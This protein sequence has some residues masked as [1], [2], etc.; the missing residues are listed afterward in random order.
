MSN[1]LDDELIP[2]ST[3]EPQNTTGLGGRI[4]T[5]FSNRGTLI[6]AIGA[7]IGGVALLCLFGYLIFRSDG[8]GEDLPPATPPAAGAPTPDSDTYSYQA[9]NESGTISV[10]LETPVF[11]SV[12]GDDFS[13]QAAFVPESGAWNPTVTNETTALWVYGSIINY[14]FGLDDTNQ[15]RSLLEGLSPGDEIRLTS[16]SGRESTFTVESL[17]LLSSDNEEIFSQHVPGITLVLLEE[18]L[19]EER[20]VATASFKLPDTQD[21]ALRGRV[22]E[23]GETA[24]LD[25][26]QVTVNSVSHQVDRP[27]APA[28]FSFFVIDY[29]VFNVGTVP[30]DANSL[31]MVLADD[32]GNLYALNPIA[33]QLGN[34]PFLTGSVA[35]GQSALAT[36]GYQ[37]P[38]GLSS[39]TLRW[40]VA[41][42]GTASQ[43]QV[44]IPFQSRQVADYQASIQLS[45]ATVSQDG[46]SL[47][48]TGQITNLGD[49]PLLIDVADVN[50]VSPLGTVFQMLS[51]N[52]AFPWTI[53]PGQALVYGVTFQRPLDPE[54]TFNLLNQSFQLTGL[55]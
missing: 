39:P 22:V 5:L 34:Y 14:V 17:E 28:G 6:V 18:D 26:L 12:T 31:N 47:L 11:L 21:A 41:I 44:N 1:P 29:Q 25:G 38:L 20:L 48:L 54:A 37:I 35:T 52:P 32:L 3:P 50:L 24:Q 23:I 46:G 15:N 33:S 30:F 16:R 8:D 40:Q 49:T 43:I 2:S 4:R 10:T 42:A 7:T 55:R 51:T 9:I 13:V 27:E 45:Q 36:A 19:D 53:A